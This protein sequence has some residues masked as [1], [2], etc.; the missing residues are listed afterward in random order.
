VADCLPLITPD[1]LHTVTGVDVSDTAAVEELIVITSTL[2]GEELGGCVDPETATMKLRVVC[3]QYTA[4][5]M[6]S[7]AGGSSAALRAEQIGDYRV[8]YQNS[9]SD[10]FDLQVLRDMLASMHG[11]SAYSVS[12]LGETKESGTPH[13]DYWDPSYMAVVDGKRGHGFPDGE[14]SL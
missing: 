4:Y 14:L 13:F 8:E 5:V 12:T 6:T 3:A 11:G 7:G 9:S 2:I 10:Q 1:F